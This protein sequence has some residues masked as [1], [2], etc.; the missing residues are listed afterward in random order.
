MSCSMGDYPPGTWAGDPRAPWNERDADVCATCA[1]WAETYGGRG[2]CLRAAR[3]VLD[4]IREAKDDD[5]LLDAVYDLVEGCSTDDC[6]TCDDW[7][8][9]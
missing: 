4:G 1:L 2:L 3:Y 8:E 6:H 9:E 5:E 7:E